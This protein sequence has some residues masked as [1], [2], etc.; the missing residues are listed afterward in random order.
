MYKKLMMQISMFLIP[1]IIAILVLSAGFGFAYVIDKTASGDPIDWTYK[2]NPMGENYLVNENC[3][4]CTGEAA[5]VQ[6]AATT[7]SNAGAKFTFSYGGTTTSY[8]APNGSDNINCISW[9]KGLGSSTLAETTYWY[10]KNTGDISQVDCE[11][12]DNKT[13]STAADTPYDY[14]DVESVMLHEFG[15]Y[16]SLDHSTVPAAVMWPTINSGTKKRTL[17][18]DDIAGIIA[19]YG[20]APRPPGKIAPIL[21]LLLD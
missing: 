11:F 5:A 9:G 8:N 20:A 16:L 15:H 4:T 13:W 3:S 2:A 19:I 14:F 7:W 21:P 1:Y 12:N 6:K 17:N 18:A 10:D